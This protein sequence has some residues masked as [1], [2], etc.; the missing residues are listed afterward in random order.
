MNDELEIR[1]VRERV[2]KLEA[3]VRFLY[4]H[5]DVE[6]VQGAYFELEP[7]DKDVAEFLKKG[8]MV[9]AVATYR[10][11]HLVGLAEAKAAVEEIRAG[12][13]L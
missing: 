13:G 5:L 6:Y 12:L 9:R 1:A 3:Q 11:V 4:K 2:S 7:A 10:A 8:D